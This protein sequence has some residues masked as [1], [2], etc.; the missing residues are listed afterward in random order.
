MLA[1]RSRPLSSG[2]PRGGLATRPRTQ[3]SGRRRGPL[4]AVNIFF[5][6]LDG[7]P[8]ALNGDAV[9]VS[10]LPAPRRT[11]GLG[12]AR[13]RLRELREAEGTGVLHQRLVLDGLEDIRH[14]SR[15]AVPLSATH[16]PG[17]ALVLF[18]HVLAVVRS[19]AARLGPAALSH[20]H[21]V[22]TRLRLGVGLEAARLA[23]GSTQRALSGASGISQ[24]DISEIENGR[25]NPI[26]STLSALTQVLGV[27]LA[28]RTGR[29]EA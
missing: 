10:G 25:A 4:I 26:L 20:L 1:A 9:F 15:A 17:G 2:V 11:P 8:V 13:R 21:E 5:T 24:H 7:A 16:D 19:E 23:Q 22:E 12:D 18:E 14:Q 3:A 29:G 27:E 6:W 28:V